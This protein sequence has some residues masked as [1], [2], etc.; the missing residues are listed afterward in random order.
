MTV[1]AMTREMGSLGKDVAAGVADELGLEII[2]H[3]VVEREVGE[4]MDVPASDVHRFLEGKQALLEKWLNKKK[5][6]RY[7][8]DEIYE[9]AAQD[10]VI[11]RGWG[12]ASLLHTVPHILRVR[13]CAPM[14][15][16]IRVMLDR[17]ETDDVKFVQREIKSNDAA[18][19]RAIRKLADG[20]W[21]NPLHYDL[22]LNT[23]RLAI[24]DCVA[25]V[26]ALAKSAAFETTKESQAKIA[27]LVIES[28]IRNFLIENSTDRVKVNNSQISVIDGEIIVA[29]AVNSEAQGNE[30]CQ[31]LRRLSG[32]R[33]VS[34]N[35][36][37]VP[38]NSHFYQ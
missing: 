24:S 29:G 31:R 8:K 5:L 9:L 1:I 4:K 36:A 28:R 12:A 18:H 32:A 25:Q 33:S 7:T 26:I 15:F 11:I 17:L 23:E 6:L 38:A 14:D 10:N 19:S 2:H 3:Q 16:R 21:M 37:V 34:N 20:D 13:V 27:D 30:F 22:T 35:L